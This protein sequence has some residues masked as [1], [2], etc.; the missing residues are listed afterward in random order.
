MGF[1]VK[2]ALPALSHAKGNCAPKL[3]E[4]EYR[5]TATV[6]RQRGIEAASSKE[7]FGGIYAKQSFISSI[8]DR[9]VSRFTFAT[10][11]ASAVAYC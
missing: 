4:G 10:R 11:S 5:P 3:G 2:A 9:G 1:P 8:E 7:M 6:E